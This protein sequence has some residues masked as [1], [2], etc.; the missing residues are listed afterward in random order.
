M[1]VAGMALAVVGYALFYTGASNLFTGGHGWGFLQSLLN[2]GEI[3]GSGADTTAPTSGGPKSKPQSPGD[4]ARQGA[5]LNKMWNDAKTI[6]KG[7]HGLGV[8]LDDLGHV[9]GLN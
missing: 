2:K 5:P 1:G 6:G 8:K 9:L 3:N 7:L 4:K